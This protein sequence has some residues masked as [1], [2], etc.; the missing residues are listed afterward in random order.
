MITLAKCG[1]LHA[2]RQV[3]SFLM[4]E[5]VVKKLFDTIAP[6]YKEHPNSFPKNFSKEDIKWEFYLYREC[7]NNCVNGNTIQ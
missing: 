2:R 3:L 1:D 7:F 4:D 6:K 5:E